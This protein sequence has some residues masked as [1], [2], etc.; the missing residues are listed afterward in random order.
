[1]K[2]KS[3][4]T[5]GKSKS[6]KIKG[7]NL[8]PEVPSGQAISAFA[9]S[10]SPG[11]R[12]I[13]DYVES[14]TTGERVEHLEKMKSERVFD[15]E[16][17]CWDVRTDK[18][19]YWV[20]TSPA[21]LYPQKFFPTVDFALSF[22][23]HKTR[24][25]ADAM[26]VRAVEI[27]KDLFRPRLLRISDGSK[28]VEKY[29]ML[30]DYSSVH[31]ILNRGD[32]VSK[33]LIE[34]IRNRKLLKLAAQFKLADLNRSSFM[35][36]YRRPEKQIEQIEEELAKKCRVKPE[37]IFAIYETEDSALKMYSEFGHTAESGD[38]PLLYL[39][40]NGKSQP[41]EDVSPISVRRE[42]NQ[43]LSLYCPADKTEDVASSAKQLLGKGE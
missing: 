43:I 5:P 31:V 23:Q 15:R 20:L 14:Q 4:G 22:H 37:F 35:G 16:Y 17:D 26:F 18:D 6:R 42:P 41:Y 7:E 25:I 40:E 10:D 32:R 9:V 24:L 29:K 8:I 19:R 2:R 38:I 21:N 30:D 36:F 13:T 11:K 34:R 3:R 12:A 28:F 1:M 33:S 27:S 39:D